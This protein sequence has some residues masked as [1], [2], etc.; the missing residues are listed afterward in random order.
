[1]DYQLD[2]LGIAPENLQGYNQEEFTHLAVAAAVAS[3]RAD[4]GMGIAAAAMALKLGFVP[5]YEER[6]D[7]VIPSAHF[8]SEL[9]APLLAVLEIPEFKDGV[10][11]MPGY[12]TS[13]M[14]EIVAKQT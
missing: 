10:S 3:G 4:C 14:G 8:E 1:M 11:E 5:L 7:L 9:I 12:D 6:Y 2:L 13:R